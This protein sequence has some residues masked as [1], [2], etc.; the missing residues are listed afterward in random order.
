MSKLDLESRMTI[1]TLL[2]KGVGASEVARLLGVSE[3][4][5][6]Y[7]VRRM[8]SGMVDGR[9][10]QPMKAESVGEAIAH[11]REQRGEQATNL[12]ALHEWLQREHGYAGSLRSVQRY[13]MR[14]YPRPLLR[15]RRRVETPAGAQTQVDW[16]HFGGVVVDGERTDLLALHLVLSHSRYEAV[17]WS[18]RKDLLS[19]LHCHGEGFKRLGGVTATVRVDNEKTAVVRGAG[20]WGVINPAYRRYAR[21]MSFHVDAC[22]PRQPQQKGKVERQVR[23][24]RAGADPR[25]QVWRDL[26]ELQAWSDEQCQR[27]AQRRRCPISGQS[28]WA[29]WQQERRLL[30]PLPEHLPEPFDLVLTRAVGFDALVSFEGRQYSVPFA[31]IGRRVEVRGCANTVQIIADNAIVAVHPRHSPQRLLIDPAHYE[32]PSTER[33]QAP[34]PLGRLGQRLQALAEA[35][36]AHRAIELYAQLAEVVS[37]L[38]ETGPSGK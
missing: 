34:P 20:A 35:P 2:S 4:A 8:Q 25:G 23:A 38:P 21:L 26:A 14:R 11:W 16:A 22:A 27:Q 17:V 1:K 37:G 33:V 31:Q 10:A 28:V 5:V 36:V 15:A 13:W 32:G 3:G 9:G 18:R 30:T 24:Q 29:T 12:A 7:H 19:W 6:R